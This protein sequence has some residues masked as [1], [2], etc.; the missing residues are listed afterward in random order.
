[1]IRRLTPLLLVAALASLSG[2]G[3]RLSPVSGVVKLDGKPV[4]GATVTFVS[5]DGKHTATAETDESGNFT[6]THTNGPGTFP[7]NYKVTVTK[8][9]KV[10]GHVPGA[11][12]T[13]DKDYEKAMKKEMDKSKPA[14]PKMPTPGGPKGIQ[15]PI[16]M[17]PGGGGASGSSVKSE[18]PE[19]Y[20]SLEKTP[21]TIK[22]PVEGP[23]QLDLK[24][25]P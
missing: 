21:F 11:E 16:G 13:I 9:P 24:S 20:A 22:V 5:D 17:M 1:M 2:C 3:P 8:Y 6:L 15:P 18:L 25:K 10:E 12:G 23:V 7:G 4:S 14:G 19:V